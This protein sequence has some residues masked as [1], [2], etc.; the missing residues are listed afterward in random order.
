MTCCVDTCSSTHLADLEEVILV[1]QA[2][3]VEPLVDECA[4]HHMNAPAHNR[5][6]QVPS[7]VLLC[8]VRRAGRVEAQDHGVV[9][10]LGQL[11]QLRA[12]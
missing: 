12:L 8:K 11:D 1:R 9:E 6:P 7:G 5:W 3:K 4:I 2:H 10:E